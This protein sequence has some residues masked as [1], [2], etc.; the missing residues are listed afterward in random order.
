MSY[1]HF[2]SF[3]SQIFL[4]MRL[5]SSV[6]SVAP[7]IRARQLKQPIELVQRLMPMAKEIE[8]CA[9][10]SG[11][12]PKLKRKN[13]YWNGNWFLSKKLKN[14]YITPQKKIDSKREKTKWGWKFLKIFYSVIFT[15]YFD[16]QIHSEKSDFF[17]KKL[18]D[19]WERNSNEYFTRDLLWVER[20][21][22]L[23]FCLFFWIKDTQEEL[24]SLI[25]W[26]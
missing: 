7:T 22:V 17:N 3:R 4:F 15:N 11:S 10:L 24:P 2:C 26:K 12:L 25:Y 19:V 8:N 9:H 18:Y 6:L 1:C 20:V 14:T 21:L 23:F 5:D 16:S 13:G